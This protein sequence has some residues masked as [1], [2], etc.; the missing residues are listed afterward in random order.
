MSKQLYAAIIHF[1]KHWI[2]WNLNIFILFNMCSDSVVAKGPY[3]EIY[4]TKKSYI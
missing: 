4:S 3:F 1:D 2:L